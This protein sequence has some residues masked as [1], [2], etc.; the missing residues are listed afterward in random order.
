M[1]AVICFYTSWFQ[2]YCLDGHSVGHRVIGSSPWQRHTNNVSS[3]VPQTCYISS[4]WTTFPDNHNLF[5]S[6]TIQ[7]TVVIGNT[8]LVR[9]DS[10]FNFIH[11]FIGQKRGHFDLSMIQHF[12]LITSLVVVIVD[13]T[14]CQTTW[15]TCWL[16]S[17]VTRYW[18]IVSLHPPDIPQTN[19]QLV[20]CSVS[21]FLSLSPTLFFMCMID[22]Q[23]SDA[24]FSL[25]N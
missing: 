11:V 21:T 17:P 20:L 2:I 7:S 8:L 1:C 10:I 3:P 25:G 9:E 22:E 15:Q 23:T 6:W 24:C 5:S 4:L 12:S 14:F 16:F 18:I 19:D 13:K